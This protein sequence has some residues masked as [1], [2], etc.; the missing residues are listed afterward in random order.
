MHQMTAHA[1]ADTKYLLPVTL[2]ITRL[3][4]RNPVLVSFEA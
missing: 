3:P 1:A 2:P 4:A